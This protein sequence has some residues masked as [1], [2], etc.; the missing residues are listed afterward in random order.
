MDPK[1]LQ[2]K[3]LR[4]PTNARKMEKNIR[5]VCEVWYGRIKVDITVTPYKIPFGLIN[6]KSIPIKKPLCLSSLLFWSSDLL[7]MIL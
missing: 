7:V 2:Q 6:C 5:L 3:V 1:T 4:K